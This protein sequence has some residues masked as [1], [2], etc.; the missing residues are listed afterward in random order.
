MSSTLS[1]NKSQFSYY[2]YNFWI[3]LT[4]QIHLFYN[5]IDKPIQIYL[6]YNSTNKLTHSHSISWSYKFA[7]L[8]KAA[9]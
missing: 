6:F 9:Y 5:R 3:V 2:I 1:T 4:T 8:E 7:R